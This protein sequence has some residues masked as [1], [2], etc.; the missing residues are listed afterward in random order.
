MR[1]RMRLAGML[2]AIALAAVMTLAGTGIAR[3]D[4][5]PPS[6]GW[7]EIYSPYLHGQVFRLG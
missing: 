5:I 3:A 1:R 4:V 6:S 7:A 2:A